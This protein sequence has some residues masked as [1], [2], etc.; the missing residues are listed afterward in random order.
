MALLVVVPGF[1]EPAT[2]LKHSILRKNIEI[3]S[4]YPWSK[5]TFKLCCY[6]P[7]CDPTQFPECM[8]IMHIPK[9]IVGDYL[10]QHITPALASEYDYVFILLDDVEL[11]EPFEWGDLLKLQRDFDMDILSP[12]MTRN[13]PHQYK[14]MLAET[15]PFALKITSCC[16]LFAYFMPSATYVRYHA[17]IMGKANPWMW[18]LDLVLTR[19]LKFRV[20]VLNHHQFCHH[21]KGVSY[22]FNQSADPQ[23]GYNA[24]LARYNETSESLANQPAILYW[25]M[26]YLMPG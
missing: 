12:A 7:V 26:G 5:V 6:D 25:I 4:K 14:Y 11:V 13:S 9:C 21:I 1:G 17:H 18:G 22:A 20:G 23:H 24:V 3:I 16:E 8:R 2:P 19:H 10:E 15:N